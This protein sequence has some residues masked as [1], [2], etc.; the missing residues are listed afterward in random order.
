MRV[1]DCRVRAKASGKLVDVLLH[2][3]DIRLSVLGLIGLETVQKHKI[4]A[5]VFVETAAYALAC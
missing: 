2:L 3:L 4:G 5:L 1:E